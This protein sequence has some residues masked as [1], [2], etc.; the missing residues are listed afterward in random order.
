[1]TEDFPNVVLRPTRQSYY[2]LARVYVH[3]RDRESGFPVPACLALHGDSVAKDEF[4]RTPEDVTCPHCL[5]GHILSDYATAVI[6]AHAYGV[7]SSRGDD[8]ESG[9]PD[10]T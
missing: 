10:G 6:L 4:M 9:T 1:M 8:H 2:G 7:P 5:R 3:A